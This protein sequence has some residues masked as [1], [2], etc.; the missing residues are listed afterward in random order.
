M[1]SNIQLTLSS[2]IPAFR[3]NLENLRIARDRLQNLAI[4]LGYVEAPTTDKDDG[5]EPTNLIE[6]YDDVGRETNYIIRSIGEYI[7]F[8]ENATGS[9]YHPNCGDEHL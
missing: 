3:S 6:A 9:A 1:S 2:L 5:A 7:D 4:Q 8:I